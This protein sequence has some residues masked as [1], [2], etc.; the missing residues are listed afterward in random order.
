MDKEKK[1]S[2]WAVIGIVTAVMAVLA[3]V[4]VFV[5]RARSKKK[6]WYEGDA[7]DCEMDDSIELDD[8]D[9][10]EIDTEIDE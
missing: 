7:I 5:L 4:L 6:A 8:A 1:S 2:L 10:E 3:V 9:L